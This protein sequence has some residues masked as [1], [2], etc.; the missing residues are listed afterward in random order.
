MKGFGKLLIV[1]G[2]LVV[3]G[4]VIIITG[5]I[6]S[7]SSRKEDTKTMEWVEKQYKTD[8]V[9]DLEELDISLVSED[10]QVEPTDGKEIVITYSDD[11][12]ES[13]YEIKEKGNKLFMERKTTNGV[14]FNFFSVIDIAKLFRDNS[15]NVNKTDPV[16][17]AIPANFKGEYQLNSVSGN[18]NIKDVN[19]ERK[20]SMNTTSGSV[21][22]ENLVV[23]GKLDSQTISGSVFLKN[24]NAEDKIDVD[25][26]SGEVSVEAVETK[27]DFK[28]NTISGEIKGNKVSA[29]N[30][31]FSTTSGDVDM[32]EISVE[33]TFDADS[34]SG[35]MT[36]S[37]T[38]A[39]SNY[40][41]D[42]DTIS[43]DSNIGTGKID[44]GNKKIKISTTSGDI[45]GSFKD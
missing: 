21:L 45:K 43:G 39:R 8:R 12:K 3:L 24:V 41:F 40:S 6:A 16:T 29:E 14:H 20:V 7:G 25:T 28:A 9:E 27:S 44:G 2:L 1:S 11:A 13:R 22:A 42:I 17:I 5:F 23:K 19:V 34:I 18:I 32:N 10:I 30:I 4:V 31:K 37:F 35:E 38:D 26:T 15:I 36:V 33:N